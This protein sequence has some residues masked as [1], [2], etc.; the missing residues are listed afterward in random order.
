[1]RIGVVTAEKVATNQRNYPIP[2]VS[3]FRQGLWFLLLHIRS[4]LEPIA[5]SS[6]TSSTSSSMGNATSWLAQSLC[7][8]E[9]ALWVAAK[10]GDL[11]ALR[12]GLARLTPETR[13][14]AEWRDPVFGASPLA[15]ACAQGH[16]ACVREL[17]AAGVDCNARDLQGN[18]P[19][20]VAARAGKSEVV[21]QLLD[22]LAVDY[23]AKTTHRSQSALDIARH[24]CR[25][26]TDGDA[27]KF[28]QCIEMIE[29]VL[30]CPP[31]FP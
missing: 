25:Q 21:K 19:L 12:A 6:S 15:N 14:Y 8:E 9:Q 24:E 1:M 30:R 31:L 26:A 17:V 29:K 20:H 11:A 5:T 16:L 10:S 28:I 3:L 18:A 23:F 27:H 13:Y 7:P 2:Q 22:T 4:D